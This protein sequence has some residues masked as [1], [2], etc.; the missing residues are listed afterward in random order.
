MAESLFPF[1]LALVDALTLVMISDTEMPYVEHEFLKTTLHEREISEDL[2]EAVQKRFDEIVVN[3]PENLDDILKDLSRY[4]LNKKQ[5]VEVW[6]KSKDMMKA[7][8][9]VLELEE[10]MV[11]KIFIALGISAAD[12]HQ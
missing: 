7:D 2:I 10:K 9:R 11:K 12:L 3:Y 1:K 4:K 8:Q 5:K 6:D